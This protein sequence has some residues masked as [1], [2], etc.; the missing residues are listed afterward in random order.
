MTAE[1]SS[2]LSSS[3]MYSCTNWTLDF[4]CAETKTYLLSLKVSSGTPIKSSVFCE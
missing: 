1:A 2:I 4:C 3:K